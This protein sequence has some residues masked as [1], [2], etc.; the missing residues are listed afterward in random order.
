LRRVAELGPLAFS[1]VTE[2]EYIRLYARIMAMSGDFMLSAPPQLSQERFTRIWNYLAA[3]EEKAKDFDDLM[4]A[5][6]RAKRRLLAYVEEEG[7]FI[8]EDG[9]CLFID[10]LAFELDHWQRMRIPLRDVTHVAQ[11]AFLT[12]YERDPRSYFYSHRLQFV[13]LGVVALAAVLYFVL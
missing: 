8:F 13:I 2:R 6:T 3:G 1:A 4:A 9:R 7:P 10:V 5:S 12:E 11:K